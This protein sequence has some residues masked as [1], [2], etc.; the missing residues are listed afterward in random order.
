MDKTLCELLDEMIA[1]EHKAAIDYNKLKREGKP[2]MNII[3]E[4]IRRDESKHADL[5]KALKSQVCE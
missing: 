4:G 1:D 5:L 3:I 2:V